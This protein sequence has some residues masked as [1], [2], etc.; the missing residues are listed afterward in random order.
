MMASLCVSRLFA[1]QGHIFDAATLFLFSFCYFSL[2]FC[3]LFSPV[4]IQDARPF[5]L[6]GI[7]LV[8][9]GMLCYP[10]DSHKPCLLRLRLVKLPTCRFIPH[11]INLFDACNHQF[12]PAVSRDLILRTSRRVPRLPVLLCARRPRPILNCPSLSLVCVRFREGESITSS[13]SSVIPLQ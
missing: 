11:V 8:F 13:A 3:F 5:V 10:A 6:P 2:S 1:L 7:C 4:C 9:R 12:S